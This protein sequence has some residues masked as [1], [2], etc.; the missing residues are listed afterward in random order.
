MF[1][2]LHCYMPETWDA[3]IKAGLIRPGDGI[4][5]SQSIDIEERLKFNN[6]AR[7]G[8]E[9]YNYVREH[10]CP[11]YIDRLQGGCFI[12]E[13]PYDME[14]VDEYRAMLGDK[15]W[16]FQMHEW[17]S[18][19]SSDFKKITSNNCPEWT[20]EKITETIRRAFPYKH[21]FLEAMNAEEYA[22]LGGVP[23]SYEEYLSVMQNLF[24]KRQAYVGG[25]LLPC[26]SFYQAQKLEI[27]AGA[28]RL[29][30]EI[31][32]QT[33]NTRIQIAYTR[34]MARAV[35]IPFGS[36]YEPWGGSPFSACCYQR[37]GKNE[38]NISAE[39]FPFHTTGD[40]GGS[41]RS[42]QWRMHLYTYMAGGSFM[43]EEW[44]MCNT[45]YDWKN[46]ELTPYGQV[47]KD[48]LDFVDRYPD[49]GE[50]VIPVAVVLPKDMPVLDMALSS[51]TYL[52]YPVEGHFAKTLS[53]AVN[54]LN[55]IFVDSAPMLGSETANLRNC[56]TPD[57]VDIIHEDSPT[58]SEYPIL[59]DC[60]GNPE[61]AASHKNSIK[62]LC[63]VRMLINDLL[64]IRLDGG[65]S[66]QITKNRT[67]GEQYVLLM[68]NSGVNRSVDQG[69]ILMPEGEI[70]VSLTVSNGKSLCPLEGN[71]SM[72]KKGV[73]TYKV[74]LPSGGWFF[75]KL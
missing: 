72:V 48:F 14:L 60:T 38:W 59:I 44:G 62:P 63:A 41:S 26:D 3:Q 56:L 68:N 52:G 49:I 22:S 35:G 46:F 69:E 32:A 9:L 67:T 55:R 24:A 5:F 10:R 45:F 40:N 57:A 39:D 34:G 11:F 71:G 1:I 70:S 43:A 37:D 15:F 50:P 19:I 42:M 4:R 33:R 6:L 13:Y 23:K 51:D 65:A 61:F 64:P 54:A 20:A 31:G 12:E 2:Y 73:N 28:K 75:A 16:G 53:D 66:M 7:V 25:D 30:P 21:T 27:E 36:Y 47:K 58:V 18:N 74:T 8:G 29:M 17:G